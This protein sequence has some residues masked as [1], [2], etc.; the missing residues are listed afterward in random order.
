MD[1]KTYFKLGSYNECIVNIII[2]ATAYALCLNLTI[3]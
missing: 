2:I 1:I 3:Y